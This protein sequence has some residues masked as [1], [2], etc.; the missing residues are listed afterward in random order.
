MGVFSLA[1]QYITGL[2]YFLC[3]NGGTVWTVVRQDMKEAGQKASRKAGQ[4][5]GRTG[6][7]QDMRKSGKEGGRAE[8]RQDRREAG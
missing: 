4:E 6:Q 2:N 8:V 3:L 5:G 7:R 1:L